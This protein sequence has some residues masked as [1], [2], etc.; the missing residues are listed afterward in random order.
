MLTADLWPSE[1]TLSQQ[2]YK[3]LRGWD[4]DMSECFVRCQFDNDDKVGGC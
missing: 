2:L 1:S 4:Y 3:Y